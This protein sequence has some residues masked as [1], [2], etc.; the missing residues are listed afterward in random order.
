MWLER[1]TSDPRSSPLR[2]LA[3]RFRRAVFHRPVDF[4]VRTRS[5][6]L[7]AVS[8]GLFAVGTCECSAELLSIIRLQLE[9]DLHFLRVGDKRIDRMCVLQMFP[10]LGRISLYHERGP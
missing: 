8:N 6:E 2:L 10:S 4:T 3:R 5:E 9:S 1:Q 7:L